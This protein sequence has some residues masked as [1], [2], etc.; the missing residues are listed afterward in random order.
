MARPREFDREAALQKAMD[1]FWAKGFAATSTDDLVKAM[2][3]GRQSLYNAFGG[4]RQL[5]V[6]ALRAY[7]LQS[8]AG[9][10]QRLNAPASPLDGIRDLLTGLAPDDD[11]RRALGC[12]G[13]GSVGEFGVTDAELMRMRAEASAGLDARLTARVR[14]GQDLGEI[15]PAADAHDIARFVQMT[16]TGLQLAARG[17]AGAEDLRKLATFAVDRVR[18]H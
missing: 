2:G 12:M 8:I 10:L 16:M 9:H 7:Q 6:E 4:K 18:A 15:A 1:L 11:A 3:L 14:E 5:Y 13:V 17:G